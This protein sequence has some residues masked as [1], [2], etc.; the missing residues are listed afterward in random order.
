[1]L[2]DAEPIARKKAKQSGCMFRI[3][4]VAFDKKGDMIGHATNIHSKWNVLDKTK[5]G[6]S[7]TARHAERVLIAKFGRRIK[8]IVICRIGKSGELRPIEPCETCLKVAEKY[9][10]RIFSVD[11]GTRRNR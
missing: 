1:M 7:G 11:D 10:I 3:S 8:N 4:A 6:R 5:K 2:F 9:G